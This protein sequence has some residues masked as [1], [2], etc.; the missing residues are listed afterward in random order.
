MERLKL[1]YFHYTPLIKHINYC[2]GQHHNYVTKTQ[3]N[4]DSEHIY[5][6]KEDYFMDETIPLLVELRDKKFKNIKIIKP[7]GFIMMRTGAIM[8]HFIA[9]GKPH[10]EIV[11][12]YENIDIIIDRT[13]Q[14]EKINFSLPR[15][16]YSFIVK[17][18]DNVQYSEKE[19]YNTGR[20]KL[21]RKP[22]SVSK[23]LS[24]YLLRRR[25]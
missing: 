24:P 14:N 7:A 10:K 19:Y 20:V 13:L 6:R 2:L 12:G 1:R 11:G 25:I 16:I 5:A 17:N 8:D 18:A 15:G 4:E 22:L 9:D 23:D 3:I 21:I